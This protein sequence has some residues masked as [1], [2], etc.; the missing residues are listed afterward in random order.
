MEEDAI[1]TEMFITSIDCY[2]GIHVHR[3][4]SDEEKKDNMDLAVAL[5][6]R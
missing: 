4:K 2:F 5:E 3:I 1:V 6:N